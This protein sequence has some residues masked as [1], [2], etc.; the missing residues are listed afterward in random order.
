MIELLVRGNLTFTLPLVAVAIAVLGS[1]I[2][3]ALLTG[4]QSERRGFWTRMV[5]QLGL[6]AL[7]FGLFSQAVSLYQ[8]MRAIEAAGDINPA[9]VYGGLKVSLICPVFG[10][11]IAVTALL[12]WLALDATGP[13]A[14][15]NRA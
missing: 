7:V 10:I 11:G 9:L 2:R 3:A 12:F 15:W 14:E 8:M 5:F 13:K 4:A 1:A 6:F